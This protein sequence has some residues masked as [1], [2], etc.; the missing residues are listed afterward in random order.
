MWSL[1]ISSLAGG[2]NRNAELDAPRILTNHPPEPLM[3]HILYSFQLE[4]RRSPFCIGRR[5]WF[6]IS[7]EG[8]V[9]SLPS[10]RSVVAR[11]RP[12]N[13]LDQT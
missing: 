11:K 7:K 3:S 12:D 9:H 5:T 13:I 1:P 6:Y 2:T 10:N 8:C 4:V